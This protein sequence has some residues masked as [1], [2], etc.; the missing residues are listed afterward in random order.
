MWI[1]VFAFWGNIIFITIS[2]DQ[3]DRGTVQPFHRFYRFDGF[4]PERE[5]KPKKKGTVEDMTRLHQIMDRQV[6]TVSANDYAL[7][8][9]IL[10]RARRITRAVV[11]DRD[12]AVGLLFARDLERFSE[13]TLADRDVRECM[14]PAVELVSPAARLE[15]LEAILSRGR[16]CLAVTQGRR[17]LGILAP[18]DLNLLRLPH[19]QAS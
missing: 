5:Q 10:M 14:T 15:D 4:P 1:I 12:N 3:S 11:L 17:I 19:R 6:A 13:M 7:D 8:A 16:A 9:L 2:Q 18:E